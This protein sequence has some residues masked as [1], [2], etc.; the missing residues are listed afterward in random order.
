MPCELISFT[1]ELIMK[2]LFN[3]DD[4][5]CDNEA[6]K[7]GETGLGNSID[8]DNKGIQMHY[9]FQILV[10][11]FNNGRITVPLQTMLGQA[12]FFQG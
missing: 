7:D 1:S 5:D 12:C 8:N 4:H 11:I 9:L 3:M 2:E 6:G 10:Y